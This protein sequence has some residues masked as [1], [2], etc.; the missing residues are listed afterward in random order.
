MCGRG[1]WVDFASGTREHG[2]GSVD[3]SINS[4]KQSESFAWFC[5]LSP[6][7]LP[8]FPLWHI[9]LCVWQ[10]RQFFIPIVSPQS[11][12]GHRQSLL[13]DVIQAG[14]GHQYR[15]IYEICME[16]GAGRRRP[17]LIRT[18]EEIHSRKIE[19]IKWTNRKKLHHKY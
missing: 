4:L 18:I 17:L 13:Q 3:L 19:I 8:L 5:L 6:V 2:G 16:W 12:H 7:T 14:G 10:S 15:G 1:K 11:L 9:P